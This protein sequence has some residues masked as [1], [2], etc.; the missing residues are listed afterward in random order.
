MCGKLGIEFN[1]HVDLVDLPGRMT[2]VKIP[3]L[4]KQK[5]LLGF[6]PK[7]SIEEGMDRVLAK[8]RQRIGTETISHDIY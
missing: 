2:L 5:Q 4:S 6:E 7:I 3:D 8:V 1:E